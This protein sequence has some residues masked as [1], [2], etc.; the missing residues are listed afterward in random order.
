MSMCFCSSDKYKSRPHDV[1]HV[2]WEVLKPVCTNFFVCCML[3]TLETAWCVGCITAA[4]LILLCIHLR[5]H[6]CVECV[7]CHIA[8]VLVQRGTLSYVAM[9]G[10][11]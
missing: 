5:L 2:L 8:L 7:G 10:T 9:R 6:A 4:Y 3:N 11:L 1:V